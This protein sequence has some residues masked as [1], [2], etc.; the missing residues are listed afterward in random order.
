MALFTNDRDW[1][2][3]R[4]INQELINN[5]I[6]QEILYYKISLENTED[7]IYGES[8]NKYYLDP[9]LL[10]C[11][12]NRN[13]QET[14]TNEFGPD[15]N[16]S[17]SF[18]FLRDD[19]VVKNTIPEIG[20]I[21]MWQENYYE[22]DGIIEDQLFGGKSPDYF[23]NNYLQNFGNSISIVLNTHYTRPDKLGII[24]TRI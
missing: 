20:D 10:N 18:G 6:E 19:L 16:R 23:M 2:L 21:I 11:L 1:G 3:L 8:L 12:I 15:V 24:K 5:I 14:S 4:T 7:N 9:I 22:V 13:P 17:L